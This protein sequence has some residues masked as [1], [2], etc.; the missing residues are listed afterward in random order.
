VPFSRDCLRPE[1]LL[2]ILLNP[3]YEY[4]NKHEIGMTEILNGEFCAR[5]RD[6]R[7][8]FLSFDYYDF[9]FVSD[10]GFRYSDLKIRI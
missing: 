8:A 6:H 5:K 10:F 7:S 2:V 3:K 4:R 9:E 1:A